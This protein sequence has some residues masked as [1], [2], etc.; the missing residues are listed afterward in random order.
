MKRGELFTIETE[1]GNMEFRAGSVPQGV[2]YIV[3]PRDP[4]LW[5]KWFPI[6]GIAREGEAVYIMKV[7]SE[8]SGTGADHPLSAPLWLHHPP[9][10]DVAWVMRADG[11]TFPIP[12]R[13]LRIAEPVHQITGAL[14]EMHIRKLIKLVGLHNPE[15]KR[16]Y[17]Y[18]EDGDYLGQFEGE[19][20]VVGNK[21]IGWVVGISSSNAGV[22]ILLDD[23][24][25]VRVDGVHWAWVIYSERVNRCP[26]S[27]EGGQQ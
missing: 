13:F 1:W 25:T 9:V 14:R 20:E 8:D 7:S 11:R 22:Q 4:A 12:L 26:S 3:M 2:G 21:R 6:F 10:K 5:T 16:L 17:L 18:S 27:G 24:D 15:K 23:Y 19:F